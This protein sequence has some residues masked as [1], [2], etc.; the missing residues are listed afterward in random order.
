MDNVLTIIISIL[1]GLNCVLFFKIWGMT[2]NVKEIRNLLEDSK[3]RKKNQKKNKFNVGD[4][5][6]VKS[7]NGVMEIMDIYDDGTLSC[8]DA[9]SNEMV[10]V[11]K[12]NAQGLGGK[13][14]L[15]T[16]S[17]LLTEWRFVGSFLCC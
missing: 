5:V 3:E 8:I 9:E 10:G 7:Y 6:T 14:V 13:K 4:H 12:E 15:I 2:E 16:D 1:A 17:M 11:F